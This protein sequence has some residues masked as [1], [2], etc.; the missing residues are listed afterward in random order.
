MKVY[1]GCSGRRAEAD[2]YADLHALVEGGGPDRA[3][4]ECGGIV[5]RRRPRVQDERAAPEE[6]SCPQRTCPHWG[7]PPDDF[8]DEE[9]VVED[10]PREAALRLVK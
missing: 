6:R 3:G 2:L 1:S 9:T 10:Q 8:A 4:R 7:R 5:R